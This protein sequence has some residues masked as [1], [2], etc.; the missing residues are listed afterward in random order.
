MKSYRNV[1]AA[2]VLTFVFST[3]ALAGDGVLHTD[4][5]PPPPPPQQQQTVGVIWTDAA[6]PEPEEEDNTLTEITLGLLQTL[7]SML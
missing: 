5:T 3:S 2:L 7:V 6:S 1:I 4:K